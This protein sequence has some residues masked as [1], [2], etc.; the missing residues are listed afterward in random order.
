MPDLNGIELIRDIRK[1]D[2]PC[3]FIVISGYRQ[4]EYAR[5]AMRYDADDYILKPIEA[6]E[7]NTAFLRWPNPSGRNT[8]PLS[9]RDLFSEILLAMFITFLNC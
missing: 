8:I 1:L 2:I 9:V 3:R 5:N 4:F 6:K 7:L